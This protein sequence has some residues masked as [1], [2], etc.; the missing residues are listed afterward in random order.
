[1]RLAFRIAMKINSNNNKMEYDKKK[2]S[3]RFNVAVH[4]HDQQLLISYSMVK[5][6]LGIIQ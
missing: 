3:N 1:M 4:T 2:Y 6:D 5:I